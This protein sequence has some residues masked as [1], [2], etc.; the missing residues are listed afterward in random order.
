MYTCLDTCSAYHTRLA[1]VCQSLFPI[2]PTLET[3]ESLFVLSH[4]HIEDESAHC[5]NGKDRA[6]IG[7]VHGNANYSD[8]PTYQKTD[9]DCC[10]DCNYYIKN[11]ADK[12]KWNGRRSRGIAAR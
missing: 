6:D 1:A 2:F 4:D 8:D 12:Q 9:N 3:V 11:S 10:N 7:P 5:G